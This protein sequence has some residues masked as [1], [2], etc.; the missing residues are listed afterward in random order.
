MSASKTLLKQT[1]VYGMATVFPRIFSFILVPLYT[2]VLPKDLYGE[3]SIIFAYMVFFNVVLSYGMETSFFR[4]YNTESDRQ[5]VLNTSTTTVFWSSM[6]FLVLGLLFRSS[7][8]RW[9]G[10]DVTFISLVVWILVLDALTMIPF[11]K[12]RAQQKPMAYALIKI[13]NVVLNL[14]LNVFFLLY[15]KGLATQFPDSVW[16]MIYFENFEIGYIFVSLL[17][18][19]LLTFLVLTPMYFKIQW[20][21]DFILWKK[22]MRYGMPILIA[23]IAF[24]INETFDK[25]LLDWLLPSNIAKSEVG[26]Y[27]ACYKLALFMTLFSTAFRLGIE[28]FFFS[29]AQNKNA[30]KTYATITEYFVIFGSVILLGVVVFADVLKTFMIMNTSYYEAMKVV[31]LIVLANLFLGI[32]HNLS[33]WYKLTDQTKMGAYIS[34]IG[35]LITLGLNVLLISPFSYMGSAFATLAAYGSMMFLSLYLGSKYYPIPYNL[36]KMTGYLGSSII[37]SGVYFYFYR[38][39]YFVGI[40]FLMIFL[41]FVYRNEKKQ[42]VSILKR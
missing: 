16:R 41:F 23:G 4:F 25:I 21:L 27:S 6:M 36:K 5:K 33:V 11:A 12:L 38:E 26:A 32:Y 24:S 20:K 22:M 14:G 7:L 13:G 35:A 29:H 40:G 42:F 8:S 2:G 15:L 3:I 31:P 28:P 18:A 30:P 34:V 10:F 17:I 39:N 9:S 1:F 19:S 37:F